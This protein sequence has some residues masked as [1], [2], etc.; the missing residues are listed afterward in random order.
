MKFKTLI[1]L[2]VVAFGITACSDAW[3]EEKKLDQN[4]PSDVS[5]QVLLPAAQAGC[6]M[7]QGDVLPRLTSIFMHVLY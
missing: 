4:R 5:M 3:L 6:G 7:L 1:I 2:A